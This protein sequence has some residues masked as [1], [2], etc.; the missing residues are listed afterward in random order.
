MSSPPGPL[1]LK[2]RGSKRTEE[3]EMFT[4]RLDLKTGSLPFPSREG[5]GG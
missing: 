1:P 2:D 3:I 4:V 5:V